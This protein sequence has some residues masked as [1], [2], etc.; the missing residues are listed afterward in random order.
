[1]SIVTPALPSNRSLN[2]R[3]SCVGSYV[4]RKIF[5]KCPESSVCNTTMV[6]KGKARFKVGVNSS[7][8]IG[9]DVTNLPLN[10]W[11]VSLRIVPYSCQSVLPAGRTFSNISS[12]T[13]FGERELIL[14]CPF[15]VSTHV[16]MATYTSTGM[17]TKRF[18]DT[19][20][21]SHPWLMILHWFTMVDTHKL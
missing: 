17:I 9:S 21:T 19:Q 8:G 20:K 7:S 14:L 16:T 15:L 4:N 12:Y 13:R 2:H 6:R 1:M 11:L 3:Q 18:I 10:A 5:C